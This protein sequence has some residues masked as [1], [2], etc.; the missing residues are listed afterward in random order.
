EGAAARH[1]RHRRTP[2]GLSTSSTA[3]HS[4]ASMSEASG[5]PQPHRRTPSGISVSSVAATSET[6]PR[7]DSTDAATRELTAVAGSS[8]GGRPG[9][10]QAAV[11]SGRA[12][13]VVTALAGAGSREL[14]R[15]AAMT[16][17][18]QRLACRVLASPLVFLTSDR[19]T[20]LAYNN[21]CV[22]CAVPAPPEEPR[23]S[24]TY[25]S[26]REQ[27]SM[28]DDVQ[29]QK[30]T[31]GCAAV[32]ALDRKDGA[33]TGGHNRLL[34]CAFC[35]AVRLGLIESFSFLRHEEAT[36]GSTVL[37]FELPTGTLGTLINCLLHC[38]LR[39]IS[40]QKVKGKGGK[41]AEEAECLHMFFL[42]NRDDSHWGLHGWLIFIFSIHCLCQLL[43]AY[44][45]TT[46]FGCCTVLMMHTVVALLVK[47]HSQALPSRGILPFL[48]VAA[49]PVF[50]ALLDKEG[51]EQAKWVITAESKQW[52]VPQLIWQTPVT[53]LFDF[54][55]RLEQW[56]GLPDPL[57]LLFCLGN[58]VLT[59]CLWEWRNAKLYGSLCLCDLCL[60]NSLQVSRG[61][62]S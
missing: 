33:H 57:F 26:P 51:L 59:T 13:V 47:M 20:R 29:L 54:L 36:S 39:P 35:T 4:E 11:S 53:L 21:A 32:P 31:K 37:V 14:V 41:H 5:C 45:V 10:L 27:K 50:G 18:A 28:L 38:L 44:E 55:L 42:P 34:L 48:A 12:L 16:L 2:S 1:R 19:R 60:K 58:I 6:S 61:V 7:D 22:V 3:A 24:G 43:L 30:L 9:P 25:L 56:G 8:L 15:T 46:C 62:P 17:R 40:E 49:L 23:H 52:G